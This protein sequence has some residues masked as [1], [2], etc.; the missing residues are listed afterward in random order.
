MIRQGRLEWRA[1]VTSGEL[2]RIKPGTP[3][4]VTAASGVQIR[5]KVR[6]IGPTVDSQ[7]RTALVYVDIPGMDGRF[8]AGSTQGKS[9]PLGGGAVRAA[10]N[11]GAMKPACSPPAPSSWATSSALLVPQSTLVMRDGF[12]YVYKL[13]DDNR[14]SRIKVQIGR[15]SGEQIEIISALRREHAA[16]GQ[17]RR[18]PQ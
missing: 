7:T 15:Q 16:G 12:A 11:M 2:G 4:L 1:E 3:A 17:W 14:V 13:G 18:L 8:P 9:A 6:M 5:G 10:T